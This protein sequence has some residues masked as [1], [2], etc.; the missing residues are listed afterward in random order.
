MKQIIL[1]VAGLGLGVA[2][3]GSSSNPTSTGLAGGPSGSKAATMVAFAQCMRSHGV[4]N[5][6]DPGSGLRVEQTGGSVS[7]NGVQLNGPAFNSAQQAC[8][9]KLPNGGRPAPPNASE[10]QS[11]LRFSQCMRSHGLPNFP[12]PNFS[13]SGVQIHIDA[14]TGMD[15]H[16]PAFKAA[17]QACGPL[18]GAKAGPRGGP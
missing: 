3:C 14:R 1:L 7:V 17:Q 11:A 13:G 2:G 12:D 6:P 15:P 8:H 16:S 5:F 10:R 18:I 4:P 9:S